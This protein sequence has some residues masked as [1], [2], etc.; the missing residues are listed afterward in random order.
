MTTIQRA[1]ALFPADNSLS[2]S[3]F[4]HE[5]WIS[6]HG[7]AIVLLKQY[8]YADAYE[9][10]DEDYPVEAILTRSGIAEK[11]KLR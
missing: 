10:C 5:L 1:L 6:K 9:S 11:A 3:K 7:P 2:K 4:P 8:G